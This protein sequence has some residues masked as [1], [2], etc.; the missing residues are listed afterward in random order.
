MSC[1]WSTVVHEHHKINQSDTPSHC[2]GACLSFRFWW[3]L[4]ELHGLQSYPE[5]HCGLYV[6]R[7]PEQ[8]VIFSKP[9]DALSRCESKFSSISLTGGTACNSAK[10]FTLKLHCPCSLLDSV[11]KGAHLDVSWRL[12]SQSCLAACSS[13]AREFNFFGSYSVE[14]IKNLPLT[15]FIDGWRATKHVVAAPCTNILEHQPYSNQTQISFQL[16]PNAPS[17]IRRY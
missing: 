11:R 7:S 16:F 10:I 2:P 17:I 14:F 3:S 6:Y 5:T 1:V 4:R 13:P 9:L 12:T 8:S 15:P